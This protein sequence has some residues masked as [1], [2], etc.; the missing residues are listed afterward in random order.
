MIIGMLGTFMGMILGAVL[1]K[2]LSK[3]YIGG[4]KGF[5]PIQFEP[6][7]MFIGLVIGLIVTLIAGYIPARGAAKVDPVS[8]FRNL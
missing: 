7:I 6:K 1:V 2:A 8:I 5:F 3:V 4:D